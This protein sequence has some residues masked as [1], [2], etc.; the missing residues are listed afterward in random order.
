MVVVGMN[1]KCIPNLF[2]INFKM[3]GYTTEGS[4][5]IVKFWLT[6][7]QGFVFVLSEDLVIGLQ[8]KPL[9]ENTKYY[10]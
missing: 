5:V 1:D 7:S 3:L 6:H 10:T 4:G 9:G 2:L 8:S